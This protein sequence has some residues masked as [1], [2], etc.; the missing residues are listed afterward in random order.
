MTCNL[1]E[2]GTALRN[3]GDKVRHSLDFQFSDRIPCNFLLMRLQP[4]EVTCVTAQARS[5]A[6]HH[7]VVGKSMLSAFVVGRGTERCLCLALM[8]IPLYRVP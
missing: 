5:P 2:I 8:D 3:Y 6:P 1:Q 4:R 7:C